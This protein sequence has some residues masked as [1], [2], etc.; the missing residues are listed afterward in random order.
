MVDH[1]VKTRVCPVCGHA[2]RANLDECKRREQGEQLEFNFNL[3]NK[4]KTYTT[5]TY[6]DEQ[7]YHFVWIAN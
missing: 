4:P 1:R 6:A 3:E 2:L 7:Q 5:H